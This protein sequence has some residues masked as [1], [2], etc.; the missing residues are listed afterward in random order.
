M[1]LYVNSRQIPRHSQ[2]GE[3]NIL[4]GERRRIGVRSRQPLG[5]HRIVGVAESEQLAQLLRRGLLDAI[6]ADEVVADAQ[7]RKPR[8]QSIQAISV[9]SCSKLFRATANRRQCRRMWREHP[10]YC[11]LLLPIGSATRRTG[12]GDCN[13]DAPAGLNAA[14]RRFSHHGY[15]GAAFS[16]TASVVTRP[17]AVN[18]RNRGRPSWGHSA[19]GLSYSMT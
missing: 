15:F 11:H 18:L 8:Q 12:R 10:D 5:Q 3:C 7:R 9:P 1:L 17:S 6:I 4:L 2:A 16:M 19:N 13:H 14:L